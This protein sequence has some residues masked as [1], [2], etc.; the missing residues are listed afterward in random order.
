MSTGGKCFMH[1]TV[2]QENYVGLI[3]TE[4]AASFK[5]LKIGRDAT[6]GLQGE[7]FKNNKKTGLSENMTHSPRIIFTKNNVI[8]IETKDRVNL[9]VITCG[10][11]ECS[12]IG[13]IY[14]DP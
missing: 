7:P 5:L 3:F 10:I 14:G 12:L 4:I 8:K 6:I 9:K 2:Y 11:T 1:N 13:T